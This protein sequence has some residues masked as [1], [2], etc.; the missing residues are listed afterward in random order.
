MPLELLPATAEDAPQLATLFLTSFS[1]TFNIKLFPRTPDVYTWWTHTLTQDLSNPLKR[2]LKVIDTEAAES[3]TDTRPFIVGFALWTLPA[4]IS[5][6][7]GDPD[8]VLNLAQGDGFH[9][10]WPES[11]DVGLCEGFFG[12]MHGRY[13]E[14]MGERR[15]YCLDLLGTHPAARRRGVG[16]MLVRWGLGRARDEGVEVY[17][18][19]TQEGKSV[20]ERLGF[21]VRRT[22]EVVDG[23]VQHSM[24]W[25]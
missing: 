18:S 4:P 5:G 12:G 19:S 8:M 20:Y 9:G 7:D 14:V 25:K 10:P 22:G 16:S 17:L 3:E 13:V 24:V 23:H 2:L 15:H 21:E 11:C 1:D 6:S